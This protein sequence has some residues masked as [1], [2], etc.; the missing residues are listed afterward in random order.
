MHSTVPSLI[1]LR[2]SRT[3]P[4]LAYALIL[5]GCFRAEV[6]QSKHNSTAAAQDTIARGWIPNCL[7]PGTF[8]IEETHNLDLNTGEGSFSFTDPMSITCD[9]NSPHTKQINR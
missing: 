5:L 8:A 6:I 7:P 2:L 9:R 1:F 4:I 3:F